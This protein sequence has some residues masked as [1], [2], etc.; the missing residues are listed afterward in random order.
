MPKRSLKS[1]EIGMIKA[2]Q[3]FKKKGWTQEYLAVEAGLTSR[4]SVWKFLTGRP[5]ESY[6]FKEICFKLDINWEEIADLPP[7]ELEQELQSSQ[8]QSKLEA[9][10]WVDIMRSQLDELI[11]IQ[12]STLQSSFD[13]TQP[14]LKEVYTNVN[15]LLEPNNQ[16]WL[17]ISDLQDSQVI[18]PRF[19]STPVNQEIMPGMEVVAKHSKL[20]LLGKPGAG[21][22][23]FLQYIALQCSQGKYRR[24]LIPLFIQLRSFASDAND[25]EDFSFLNYI[26]EQGKRCHL[27]RQEVMTLVEEGKFLV[28][29]DGLDEITEKDN[30]KIL[31]EINQFSQNFYKNSI[32]IT[33]RSGSHKYHFRGFIYVELADFNQSQ[34]EAFSQKWFIATAATQ[35]EGQNK[36]EQFIQQLSRPENQPIRELGVTPILLNLICSVFKERSNFPTKRAKLYQTGLDILLKRWDQA[37][38]IQRDQVY[39]SLSLPDKIKLLCQ[40]AATTFEQ[41]NYFFETDQVLEIIENYLQNISNNPT[42][43]ETLW[44]NSEAVLKA[45]ELQHGILIERAKDIYSFSHLTFQEYLTARKIITNPNLE[46]LEEDLQKLAN[47]TTNVRWREVIL[48]TA[49]MLPKADI[50]IKKIKEKVDCLVVEEPQLNQFLTLINQ[51]VSS[52]ELSYKPSAIRSFYFTLLQNR[53][54]NLAVSLDVNLASMSNLSDELNLDV[55]LARA[56][57]D[58]LAFLKDPDRKKLV[59]LCFALDLEPK[60]QLQSNFKKALEQIKSQLPDLENSQEG[61]QDWWQTNGSNWIEQFRLVLIEHRQIGHQWKLSQKQQQLWQQYYSANLF[62]IEC[63]NSDCQVSS[64]VRKTI[65]ETVLLLK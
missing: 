22:S 35:E 47:H 43:L 14:L 2:K 45:I 41:E 51:K 42:D 33:C 65:E 15:L 49:S 62:L 16:R 11:Q 1:S 29:L 26:L 56:F 37:R 57:T 30:D 38:G 36:A 61:L 39:R 58:S 9:N 10:N 3:A 25:K 27:P 18:I 55:M 60:F 28:L 64:E 21:K 63:L 24:D 48:L 59:N 34:I 4:Q 32:I 5:I 46:S 17:E 13:L 8:L 31:E 12:C 53:D 40:I 23:T 52:M 6:V 44:L 19:S 20:M 50:L 7:E 54:L